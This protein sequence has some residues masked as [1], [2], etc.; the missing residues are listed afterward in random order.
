MYENQ[1]DLLLK[2]PAYL[3]GSYYASNMNL[4]CGGFGIADK[5]DSLCIKDLKVL[6]SKSTG[7]TLEFESN[8]ISNWTFQSGKDG[9]TAEQALRIWWHW[10]PGSS[11]PSSVDQ[12]QFQRLCQQYPWIVMLIFGSN[13]TVSALMGYELKNQILT[14]K[15][16]VVYD[17]T[18][19]KETNRWKKDYTDNVTKTG[20]KT[21]KGNPFGF[22]TSY[23][24]LGVSIDHPPHEARIVDWDALEENEWK[25][26]KD[27][28]S[29]SQAKGI[30]FMGRL[31]PPNAFKLL[32]EAK[33]KSA[34]DDEKDVI[35][36]DSKKL[37]QIK[38]VTTIAPPKNE[39]KKQRR[40]RIKRSNKL[41]QNKGN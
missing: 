22:G 30:E 5:D 39:T 19:L 28:D 2:L 20:I 13:G 4:E 38:T 11:N 9:L 21:T 31:Y 37:A 15:L 41:V 3:K 25:A 14:S 29:L 24:P 40:R 27:L 6:P 36:K 16:D 23:Y 12:L 35:M 34:V 8:A 26:A 1:A 7:C 33:D 32:C 10:H 17:F 18:A